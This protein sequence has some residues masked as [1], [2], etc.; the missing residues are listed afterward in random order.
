MCAITWEVD[1]APLPGWTEARKVNT[2]HICRHYTNINL[3]CKAVVIFQYAT[4]FV[5]KFFVHVLW[6]MGRTL[7]QAI[8]ADCFQTGL[9]MKENQGRIVGVVIVLRAGQS[10][11]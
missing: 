2:V 9:L 4:E 6:S 7:K 11:I 5:L 3:F 8:S 1:F 10:G